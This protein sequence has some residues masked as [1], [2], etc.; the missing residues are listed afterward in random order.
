MLF[1]EVIWSKYFC[2]LVSRDEFPGAE[3]K[4]SSKQNLSCRKYIELVSFIALVWLCHGTGF[5]LVSWQAQAELME[6]CNK[7]R[8]IRG[9]TKVIDII[10]MR[11]K[12][13]LNMR[14][15]IWRSWRETSFIFRRNFLLWLSQK[16][17]LTS[18]MPEKRDMF[19]FM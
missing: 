5:F 7:P 14:G 15:A 11:Q 16:W 12:I 1:H 13:Y 8:A 2:I 9:F 19:L 18:E 10:L 6:T 3:L 4:V 17:K